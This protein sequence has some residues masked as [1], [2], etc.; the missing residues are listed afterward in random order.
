M[1]KLRIV[2]F[3]FQVQV[4]NELW[5]GEGVWAEPGSAEEWKELVSNVTVAA[6]I[7][8]AD[9]GGLHKMTAFKGGAEKATIFGEAALRTLQR[10]E[11]IPPS[12]PRRIIWSPGLLHRY[13]I[14]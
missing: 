1:T 12:D 10:L 13:S 3:G 6:M 8:V 7:G 14:N 5:E 4:A 11:E 2:I 9:L